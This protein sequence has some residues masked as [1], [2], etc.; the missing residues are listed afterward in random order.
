MGPHKS[1]PFPLSVFSTICCGEHSSRAEVSPPFHV[2]KQCG[3]SSL[4][5]EPMFLGVGGGGGGWKP[6]EA[7]NVLTLQSAESLKPGE[8]ETELTLQHSDR[9]EPPRA[10][11]GVPVLD[12]QNF[13]AEENSRAQQRR[14]L[15]LAS[16]AF[17]SKAPSPPP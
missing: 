5:T 10:L 16:Y 17:S 13:R 12:S 3:I 1:L 14:H 9:A 8:S 11:P 15:A 7:G 6:G 4:A 2:R